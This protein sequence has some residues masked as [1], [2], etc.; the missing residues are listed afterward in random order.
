[1]GMPGIL[2]VND[3]VREEEQKE[4]DAITS[5]KI[6][7]LVNYFATNADSGVVGL[8]DLGAK[9]PGTKWKPT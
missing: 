6:R 5:I 8:E 1:M 3:A 7:A 2:H 9:G 4:L